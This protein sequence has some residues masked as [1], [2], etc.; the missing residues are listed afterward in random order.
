M[1]LLIG[2]VNLVMGVL[3]VIF[4]EAKFDAFLAI[5]CL[6][7]GLYSTIIGIIDYLHD[8]EYE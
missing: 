1:K 4:G 6:S 2:V 8:K 3:L 5:T 7:I